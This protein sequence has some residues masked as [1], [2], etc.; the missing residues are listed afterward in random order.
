M[1]HLDEMLKN[2]LTAVVVLLLAM[3]AFYGVAQ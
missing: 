2:P 3:A 1:K